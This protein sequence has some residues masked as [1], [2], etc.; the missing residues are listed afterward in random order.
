[1]RYE[2]RQPTLSA[3]Q[4]DLVNHL[5]VGAPNPEFYDVYRD[6]TWKPTQELI[7]KG[8]GL[9]HRRGYIIADSLEGVFYKGNVWS[10]FEDDVEHIG[11]GMSSIS[12]GD[13]LIDEN[14]VA[15]L[16]CGNAFL[17]VNNN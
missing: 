2:I 15:S 5:T 8:K 11:K 13:M 6:L 4:R 12:I 7:V 1:M 9:Y 16:V 3:S 17:L 10:G 14:G